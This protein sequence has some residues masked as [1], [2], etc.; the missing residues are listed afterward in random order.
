MDSNTMSEI[1][2]RPFPA[3]AIKQ[4][5]GGWDRKNNCALYFDYV[6]IEAVIRRLIEA[7]G[8]HYEFRVDRLEAPTIHWSKYN[9]DTGAY[10]DKECTLYTA[11]VSLTI[12]GCTR[13]HI[14]TCRDDGNVDD[15]AKGAV[16]DGLK[17]AATLWGVALDLY[18][19]PVQ[20]GEPTHQTPQTPPAQPQG[21]QTG[22]VYPPTE[23]QVKFFRIIEHSKPWEL[24]RM[25]FVGFCE[26]ILG[27]KWDGDCQTLA[28]REMSSLLDALNGLAPEAIAEMQPDSIEVSLPMV[29]ESA[30]SF[31]EATIEQR[32]LVRGYSES[33]R[34]ASDIK[35]FS[36]FVGGSIDRMGWKLGNLTAHEAT[37]AINA[38]EAV[39]ANDAQAITNSE[40]GADPF[41][42]E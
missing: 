29:N 19:K 24:R 9:K 38:L 10:E 22:K 32:N 11:W 13:Q 39:D 18:D 16:S 5:E 41:E 31:H 35:A 26:G 3:D 23:A 8:N 2:T 30:P 6:G 15:G 42:N 28:K 17:K 37:L 27:R 4:R 34:W 20:R 7:T 1:L 25:S 21:G 33:P 40:T 14:G 36:A 12:D